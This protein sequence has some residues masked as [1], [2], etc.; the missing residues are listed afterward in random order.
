MVRSLHLSI[1]EVGGFSRVGLNVS[2]SPSIWLFMHVFRTLGSILAGMHVMRGFVLG[3]VGIYEEW[4][5]VEIY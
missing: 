5:I 1:F 2:L 3:I 4:L